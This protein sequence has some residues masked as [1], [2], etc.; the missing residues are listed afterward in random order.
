MNRV[1]ILL[2]AY[3]GGK[4][5]SEQ[6][7]SIIC[8]K[9]VEIDVFISLDESNDDSG[10]IINSY[11]KGNENIKIFGSDNKFG[12]A[13]ANFFYLLKS[14]NFTGYD[15]IAFADQDDIWNVDKL[16]SA[17]ELMKNND[18]HGYSSDVIAFW[19]NGKTKKI[20]KS[21]KQVEFDFIFESAGPGCT[22]VL[23]NVLA[24]AIKCSLINNSE[25]IE[26]LWLHDWYCY[27]FARSRSFTWVIDNKPSMLYRQHLNNSVGANSGLLSLLNRIN[28][29]VRGDAFDK[30]LA[31]ACFLGIENLPPVKLLKQ[32]TRGACLKLALLSAK[33]R[34]KKVE[35]YVFFMAMIVCS[36]F[37][38]K[39]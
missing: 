5:L 25:E 13:G 31:Q 26:N 27:A 30:V 3:N 19:E 39:S 28:V 32:R 12:S 23:S 16:C 34:R 9:N 7:D 36:L 6:L 2:A 33:C 18:A 20:I 35:K 21:D 17:I 4:Y 15:Y 37:R 22:F 24:N 8:Q 1:C 14:V 38:R 11:R 29:V 10:S